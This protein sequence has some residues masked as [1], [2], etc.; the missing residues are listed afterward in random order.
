[1]GFPGNL[2]RGDQLKLGQSFILGLDQSFSNRSTI[3]LM[4]PRPNS[5]TFS[6]KLIRP[7][8]FSHRLTT[9]AALVV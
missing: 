9:F 8:S 7:R 6:V 1:M 5:V 4:G 2:G 3:C